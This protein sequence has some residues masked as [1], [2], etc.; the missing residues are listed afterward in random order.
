MYSRPF[1]DFAPSEAQLAIASEILRLFTVE[2]VL[3]IGAERRS[4][5]VADTAIGLIALLVGLHHQE[6]SG[7]LGST[8]ETI[9]RRW[10][11]AVNRYINSTDRS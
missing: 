1:D 11:A 5:Q 2:V 8:P 7:T 4:Q 6:R 3:L 10:A 9:Q